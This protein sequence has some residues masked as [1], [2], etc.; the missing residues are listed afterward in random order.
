VAEQG[1]QSLSENDQLAAEHRGRRLY[2]RERDDQA[3]CMIHPGRASWAPEDGINIIVTHIDIPLLR[4]R[5]Q[6]VSFEWDPE[7]KFNHPGPYVELLPFGVL[8]APDWEGLSG[9]IQGRVSLKY[10]KERTVKVTARIPSTSFHLEVG[11]EQEGTFDRIRAFTGAVSVEE[12]HRQLRVRSED[13]LGAA[14]LYFVPDTRWTRL[15]NDF[16]CTYG[17]DDRAC[18]SAAVHAALRSSPAKPSFIFGLSAEEI[19]SVGGTGR[20]TGFFKR[21]INKYLTNRLRR[22]NLLTTEQLYDQGIFTK[23]PALCGD[24]CPVMSF[25]EMEKTNITPIEAARFGFGPFISSSWGFEGNNLAPRYMAIM[26]DAL[27][28]RLRNGSFRR[29]QVVGSEFKSE[30]ASIYTIP[31]FARYF[32]DD[33]IPMVA[34]GTPVQDLHRPSGEMLYLWDWVLTIEAYQGYLE[35][36]SKRRRV[37]TAKPKSHLKP[38]T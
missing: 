12:L 19:G 25:N 4:A 31:H 11:E 1:F 14:E 36:G 10:N 16:I 33:H 3:F 37:G 28:T 32:T 34:V 35:Y 30:D 20:T 21:V 2:L 24:V 27:D 7:K 5:E 6:P 8:H 9:H 15:G 17:F 38:A 13:D 29:Y 22:R 23:Y 18:V 26:R